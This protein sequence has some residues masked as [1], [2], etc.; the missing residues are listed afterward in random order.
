M[1]AI[2]ENP[3]TATERHGESI[4]LKQ[5]RSSQ[6]VSFKRDLTG[7][8]READVSFLSL[9]EGGSFWGLSTSSAGAQR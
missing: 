1:R 4:F 8:S 5:L 2:L 7:A 9:G 6:V 3:L